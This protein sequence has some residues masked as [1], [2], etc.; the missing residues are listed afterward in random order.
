M[1]Y[2]TYFDK[3]NVIIKD[4]LTNLGA[5][6]INELYYGGT[7][8]NPQYSRL[9]FHFGE[10][11]LKYKYDNC[12]LGDLSKVKHTLTLYPSGNSNFQDACL[13]KDFTLCLYKLNQQWSEGCG[14]AEN[15]SDCGSILS[16]ND[17]SCNQEASNW[18][19]AENTTEWDVS[20]QTLTTGDLITCIDVSCNI[21]QL[22]IDI[23]DIVNEFITGNTINY[24][25]VLCFSEAQELSPL[26]NTQFISFF[27]RN[28]STYFQPFVQTEYINPIFD[29]RNR[30][31]AGKENTL[32]LYSTVGGNP[33]KLDVNPT[34]TIN[35]DT[36]Q[37]YCVDKGIYAVDYSVDTFTECTIYTDTWSNIIVNGVARPDVTMDFEIKPADEYFGF[38]YST[39]QPKKFN[40]NYRGL[41][42]MEKIVQGDKR[43]VFVLVTEQYSPKVLPVDGIYYTLY[44][45]QGKV[46][47]TIIEWTEMN[48]GVCDNWFTLDTSWLIPQL[49]HIDF[50][51][52]S[53]GSEMTYTDELRFEIAHETERC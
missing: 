33:V 10:S 18:I 14:Q 15:C 49:Y 52:V 13:A 27:A 20:G 47:Q 28:T 19:Y 30:F 38:G 35:C 40:F 8:S 50:K 39:F 43:K 17:S 16:I 37:S 21:C 24:G 45:K 22:D 41:S 51:I 44:V 12:E 4:S 23:T 5:S 31:Y 25:F 53:A 11:E 1:I 6:P 26:Q 46:R 2:R 48:I 29:D 34:V 42:R 3:D 9:L 7:L 36:L 32:Y